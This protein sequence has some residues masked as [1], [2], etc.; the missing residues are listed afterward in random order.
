MKILRKLNI[1]FAA[2]LSLAIIAHSAYAARTIDNEQ[3]LNFGKIAKP[4]SGT[5]KVV[6]DRFGSLQAGTTAVTLGGFTAGGRDRI[7]SRAQDDTINI[8]FSN[9]PGNR[10]PGLT[11]SAFTG[12]YKNIN[13]TNSRNN[14]PAPG[15]DGSAVTY[16]ATLTVDS[17]VGTGNKT[18][19]YRL[20]VN[21]N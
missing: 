21:Y 13:F 11:L 9:C 10:N 17:T 19:C 1:I 16:G 20:E 2:F 18:A 8:E 14:L 5:V 6:I 3:L 12:R 15:L 7:E 4:A